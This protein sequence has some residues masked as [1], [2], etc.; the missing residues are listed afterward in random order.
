MDYTAL[1]KH[2]YRC[3]HGFSKEVTVILEL[4]IIHTRLP[5]SYKHHGPIKD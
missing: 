5:G 2:T 1:L 4:Q 3:G